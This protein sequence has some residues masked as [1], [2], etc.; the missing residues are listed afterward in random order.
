M[1]GPAVDL[2]AQ[3]FTHRRTIYGLVERQN[4]PGLFRTFD[5]AS[6]DTHSPQRFTTTV[7]QQALFLM[8]SP[9][10]GEQAR[11]LAASP[12]IQSAGD[13]PQGVTR[14]YRRVLGRAPTEAELRLARRLCGRRG[15][16]PRR[17]RSFGNM[18][19]APGTPAAAGS[20]VSAH[21]GHWTG[22]SVARRRRPIPIP[23]C[24]IWRLRPTADIP[25]RRWRWSAVGRA[26]DGA[27]T[28]EGTLEHPDAHGDGVE[29]AF[30][31]SSRQGVVGRW[32]AE[33][34]QAGTSVERVE[35]TRGDTIDF[36]VDARKND[37][38]DSFRWAPRLRLLARRW[39]AG[40]LRS[41]RGTPGPTSMVRLPPHPD[42]W[43][44]V[45]Q[46]LLLTNE[47]VFLD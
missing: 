12:E 36:V 16:E 1:G 40:R 39:P 3:P 33:H 4:L 11:L 47:F 30:V 31:V 18:A 28:V 26:A 10:V 34:N 9:F 24:C 2:I 42:A 15:G 46:V 8:N 27:V 41:R 19:T 17:R 44:R 6:P 37:S 23:C 20:R 5:F 29:A 14:L 43:A 22:D 21:L 38:Y 7:P 13:V 45:A 32:I 35:V 25:A